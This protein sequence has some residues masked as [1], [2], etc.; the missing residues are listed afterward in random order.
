MFFALADT[1][2]HTSHRDTADLASAECN[3]SGVK[4][5]PLT[6]RRTTMPHGF[7]VLLPLAI[8]AIAAHAWA[9]WEA[10][11]FRDEYQA[12]LYVETA[13]RYPEQP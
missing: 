4:G 2:A 10:K 9:L 13:A 5:E 6:E 3:H 8:A 7:V 1:C 12:L 11:C